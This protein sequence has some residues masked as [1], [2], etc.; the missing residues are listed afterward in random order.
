MRHVLAFC[1]LIA[2]ALLAGGLLAMPVATWIQPWWPVSADRIVHRLGLLV[3]LIAIPIAF[4]RY[5]YWRRDLLGY[6]DPFPLFLK[7]VGLGALA[8]ILI[9]AP[10]MLML[11][12]LGVREWHLD[13]T[14]LAAKFLK[15]LKLA[16]LSGLAVA[17]VEEYFFRGAMLGLF[18]RRNPALRAVLL[19][20]AI[21]AALHFVRSSPGNSASPF[22][23]GLQV[24]A[25]SFDQF[26][27]PGAMLDSYAALMMAGVLLAL[28]RLHTGSIALGIGMHASWVMLIKLY[29][30]FTDPVGHSPLAWLVGDYDGVGGWLGFVWLSLLAL[31]YWR[32]INAR[33]RTAATPPRPSA[34][35]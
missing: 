25:H 11:I 21:Y 27:T 23:Y 35:R 28:A 4:H 20:S 18:L 30:Q 33:R 1:L 2:L 15:T 13:Y 7:R 29:K 8:G 12:V 3:V 9:L 6:G 19:S 22:G 14:H 31:M 10:V 16:L 24:L 17:I 34:A 26:L 32:F 5:G